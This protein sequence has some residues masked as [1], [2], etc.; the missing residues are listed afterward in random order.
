MPQQTPAEFAAAIKAQYPIY[1]SVPDDQLVSQILAKFPAYKSQIRDVTVTP[2]A[3]DMLTGKMGTDTGDE[4]EPDTFW[5]GVGKSLKSQILGLTTNPM[6]TGAAHPSTAG[7]FLSLLVP[8][9]MA[10][11]DSG[12]V[13]AAK[14]LA[15][16]G[17][18]EAATVSAVRKP[19]AMLKG[20]FNK[21]MD[22]VAG[23][24]REF[25]ESPLFKQQGALP[26]VEGAARK[27]VAP[28]EATGTPFSQR[29]LYQQ[30]EEM[31]DVMGTGP[32]RQG[33]A[34]FP[35]QAAPVQAGR[36]VGKAPTLEDELQSILEE[37]RQPEQPMTV[38]GQPEQTMT[39]G[40]PTK[41]SGKFGKSGNLGQAGGYTSGRPAT[42]SPGSGDVVGSGVAASIPEDASS[43]TGGDVTVTPEKPTLSAEETAQMLRRMY[44]SRDASR[45]LYGSGENTLGR[46]D[47]IDAIKRLSPGP[48]QVPL[49]AEARIRAAA[50]EDAPNLEGLLRAIIEGKLKDQ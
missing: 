12:T 22:P 48:S 44:G 33:G 20:M 23:R 29:P 32:T 13:A 37:A 17:S 45:M 35:P 6:V 46:P 38:S 21:A 40:G 2:T 34:P 1:Q 27:I 19:G 50:G 11:G 24:E 10:L 16:A 4:H 30:M 42:G 3:A 26:D 47:A 28:T 43:V 8:S 49:A 25:M 41:Q 18:D 31:G 7:D 14:H 36:V 39:A 9:E 15:T 5:G